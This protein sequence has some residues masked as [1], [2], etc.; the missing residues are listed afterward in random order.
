MKSAIIFQRGSLQSDHLAG[1]SREGQPVNILGAR[2]HVRPVEVNGVAA[3]ALERVA[4]DVCRMCS[5]CGG[6]DWDCAKPGDPRQCA[7][8]G[9]V[10]LR[11]G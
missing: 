3:F 11:E 5:D 7:G 8:C 4:G 6:F 2:W 10:R 1:R 9:S